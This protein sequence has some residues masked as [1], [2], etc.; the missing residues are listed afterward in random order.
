MPGLERSVLIPGVGRSTG[1]DILRDTAQFDEAHTA[2]H[3][4]A[5]QKT[6]AC[7]GGLRRLR[8]IQPIEPARCRALPRHVTRLRHRSL[9]AVGRFVIANGRINLWIRRAPGKTAI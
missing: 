1:A 3:Q 8:V 5:S 9:H 2:L 4:T 6:L 7:I